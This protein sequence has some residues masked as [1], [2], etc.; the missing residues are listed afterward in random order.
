MHPAGCGAV[1]HLGLVY[2]AQCLLLGMGMGGYF[3]DL[4]YIT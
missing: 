4:A 2:T 3:L 1:T